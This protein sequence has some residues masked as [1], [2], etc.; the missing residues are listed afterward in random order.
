MKWLIG[1]GLIILSPLIISGIV[2]WALVW[3]LPLF[4]YGVAHEVYER[5][6]GEKHDGINWYK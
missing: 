1:V 2:A 6:I 5:I 4:V 3:K